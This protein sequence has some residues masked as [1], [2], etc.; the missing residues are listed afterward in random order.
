M[1]KDFYEAWWFLYEHRIFSDE[2]GDSR[3]DLCLDIQIVK[4]NPKTNSIE[5]N[6]NLN[7][8]TRVW[9]EC[10]MYLGDN[11]SEHD[12]ELDC[13]S[14]TFEGAILQLATLVYKYYGK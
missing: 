8:S 2:Y 7:T 11:K 1:F 6:M 4:V 9:L 12:I 13:G 14:E 5:D 3:L 10:G